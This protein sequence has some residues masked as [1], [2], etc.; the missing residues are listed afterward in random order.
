MNDLVDQMFPPINRRAAPEYTDFNFW[1]APMPI[2]DLPDFTPP[3][4]TLSARSDSSRYSIRRLTNSITRRSSRPELTTGN[5]DR[6]RASSPRPTSPLSQASDIITEEV[7]DFELGSATSDVG[8]EGRSSR[9]R[10]DS[11]PGSLEPD[12]D[13]DYYYNRD[14]KDQ[15]RK[16]RSWQADREKLTW[17]KSREEDDLERQNIED[18]SDEEFPLGEM[19]FSSVPVSFPFTLPTQK[20]TLM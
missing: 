10:H 16:R 14:K 12:N 19:D 11:M 8:S 6:Q 1:R 20:V 15:E 7:D 18:L 9:R 13:F 2:V 3:S 17:P 5:S 4:P